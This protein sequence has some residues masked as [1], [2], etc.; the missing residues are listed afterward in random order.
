M[1]NAGS[2]TRCKLTQCLYIILKVFYSQSWSSLV[3][4]LLYKFYV[5][6]IP[7]LLYKSYVLVIRRVLHARYMYIHVGVLRT[8]RKPFK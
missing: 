6:V 2:C 8:H 7:S 1:R 5:L 3:S 4:A